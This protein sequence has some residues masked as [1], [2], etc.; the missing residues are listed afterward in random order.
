MI[1]TNAANAWTING[2]DAGTLGGTAF[3]AIANLI[4]G[5]GADSF[6][7]AGTGSISGVV[8]GGID[9]SQ[10]ATP[11]TDTLDFG[12][13]SGPV[14]VDLGAAEV[15]GVVGSFTA[16][17]R[18]KGSAGGDTLV[19]PSGETSATWTIDAA[20]AGNVAGVTFSS[21]ENLTGVS[22][23][24]S[25][26][27]TFEA[28]GSISGTVDGGSGTFDSI[29]VADGAG[30]YTIFNPASG[31]DNAGTLALNG[32]TI[33]YAGIDRE[34]LFA[35]D[36]LARSI[37]GT[38]FGDTIV[39]EDIGSAS[40]GMM[41]VRFVGKN[42]FDGSTTTSGFT[43][44]APADSLKIEGR[45]GSDSIEVK[46][47]D[48]LFSAD[49]LLYGS[50]LNGFGVPVD[51]PFVDSIVFSGSIDTHDGILDAWADKIE[52]GDFVHIDV[53]AQY[54]NFRARLVG[55]AE[56]ENLLP[57]FG[58]SRDVS[59]DIGKGAQ[60]S[61]EGGIF[62]IAQ[63]E[64]KNI[65]GLAGAPREVD[66]FVIQPLLDKVSGLTA[67]PV[68]LLVKN[69]SATITLQEGAKV[70]SDSTVG[71]YATASADASGAASGSLFSI[72][73]SRAVGSATID[74]QKDVEIVSADEAVVITSTGE[75]TASLSSST[76]RTLDSTPNPGGKDAQVAI[77]IAVSDANAT[78]HVN[79][80]EG[81]TIT[82][83]K[84]ANITAGGEVS[85]EAEAESGIFA[86]G[87]AG[88]AFALQFS[89]ADIKTTMLGSVT[90]YAKPDYTVKIEIDP[91]VTDPDTDGDG[92]PTTNPPVGYV[93]YADNK[94][95]VGGNSLVTEDTIDYTNRFGTSIGGLVDGT[96]YYVVTVPDMPGWI[97]LA[98]TETQAIKAGL[99]FLDGNVVD[100]IDQSGT[101]IATANNERAFEGSDV[102]A[103]DNT[104]TLRD[105]DNAPNNFNKF[106][107]GQAVV[108][109]KG[110]ADIDGL[111]DGNTYYV[112]VG[113]SENNLQ[114]DTRFATGQVVQLAESENEARAGVF[115]DIGS[116]AGAGG[117]KLSA[118]HVLDSNFAT[119]IGVVAKL[120]AEDKA[121]AS[122]GLQ[123][124]DK[125][126][127]KYDKFK[128][129]VDTNLGDL[130]FSKLTKSYADNQAKANSG[131][132]SELSVAGALAFSFGDHT[133]T[134][135]VGSKA[136]LKSNE[137]LEVKAN[138]EE[139]Y[140]LSAQSN[141]EPQDD[142]QGNSAGSS[143]DN[144]VSVAVDI[145]IY[146]NTATATVD[147]GAK[148]DGLRATRV[149][150]GVLYPFLTRPDKYIPLS[151]GELVDSIRSE[152]PDAITKYLTSTLGLKDSLFNSWTTA[153]AKADK[154]GIAGSVNV[155]VLT[156]VATATVKMGALINQDPTWHTKAGNDHPNQAENQA[157]LR[158][159]EVV[160]VEATNYMQTINMT[161][162]FAL[163]TFDFDPTTKD[164]FK[165]RISL[166]PSGTSGKK[167]GFGGAFFISVADN[168]THAV[169]EDG[170]EIYSGA[171]GGFNMKAEQ[172]ILAVNLVQAGGEGGKLAIGGSVAY[173]GITSD[174]LARLGAGA[175]V[176][177]RDARL[178]AG[179]L[180]TDVNWVGG[181]A[182]GETI[183]VGIAVGI[184][185][186]DRKT[187]AVIGDPSVLASD[188]T[189]GAA[190]SIN[191]SGD[192][193]VRAFV[194]G[195]LL[196]FAVAGAAATGSS[197]EAPPVGKAPAGASA[198]PAQ[199]DSSIASQQGT[200]NAI[201]AA[202]SLN[203]VS[204]DTRAAIVDAGHINAGGDTSVI[205]VDDLFHVAATGGVA[206]AKN[207]GS[208]S[209]NALAGALSFNNLDVDTRAYV[210]DT[211]ITSHDL[212][213]TS[214]RSGDLITVSASGAASTSANGLSLAGS[215]SVNRLDNTTHAFLQGANIHAGG[216]GTVSALDDSGIIAIG[217]AA[218]IGGAT[219][220]GFSIG[221]NEITGNTLAAID[222]STLS[223]GGALGLTAKN[224]NALRSVGVSAGLGKEDSIAVTIGVNLIINTDEARIT[225]STLTRA[226]SV[227]LLAQDDSVLQAIG[228]AIA[229]GFNG[230]G[231]GGSLG[232]NSVTN[233]IKA[234]IEDSSLTGVSGAVGV[235][236]ES[237]EDDALLDGKI[238][239]AAIGAAA[240]SQN[241]AAGGALAL[242]GII[243]SVDAHVSL[244]STIVAGGDVTVR[245]L[246]E[247]S[248]KSLTGGAAISLGGSAAGIGLSGN[249]IA[250]TVTATIDASSVT[251]SG[252]SVLVDVSETGA[253]D[254]I[255]IGLAGSTG[256]LAVAGSATINVIVD[257]V[258]ASVAGAATVHAAGNV[259]VKARNAAHAGVIAGQISASTGSAVGA[260]I[261]NATIVNHTS[262]WIDG[263]ATVTADVAFGTPFFTD[264]SGRSVRGVSIEASSPKDVEI[265]A[266]GG[267]IASDLAIAGSFSITVIDD[268][269]EAY[270]KDV[271]PGQSAGLISS[272]G[273]VNVVAVSSFGL[274]GAAGS[275]AIGGDAG[276]G[277][278]ADVGVA[279]IRTKAHI[280]DGA[281]VQA[282]DSVIVQALADERILSISI[283]GAIS[284]SVAVGVTAGVSVL[285]LDTEA[286][287][288]QGATASANGNAVVQALD[289]THIDI[290]TGSIAASGSVAVGVSG[291]VSVIN[292][293]TLSWIGADAQVS[294][295][296]AAGEAAF[297]ANTG[298]FTDAATVD[299]SQKI[300]TT[301]DFNTS[302]VDASGDRIVI[303][304]HGFS[305]DQEVIYSAGSQAVRGL[306]SGKRYYVHVVDANTI[307]LRQTA[308][309]ASS[310]VNLIASRPTT[311]AR[312]RAPA[313]R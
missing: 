20:D 222:D 2:A 42:F 119:G 183:G 172:A 132:Q 104:I 59:I 243:N 143:A 57:A 177:G 229:I 150:S 156:N 162:I 160:S 225:G 184:N 272:H 32:K 267:S 186:L 22:D 302:D 170:A 311:A 210:L 308:G 19:G 45:G 226:A 219:G 16:I 198:K 216:A 124:E 208:Q 103:A 131:G 282:D 217:G 273:D 40:D 28:G 211:D 27:F 274:I 286:W 105:A 111:V 237:T 292:K 155:L 236:A 306:T 218:A 146:N 157:D 233:T 92:D 68:K 83:G 213:V 48:S 287:I 303:A 275:I 65:A 239:S 255:A 200:T 106:E 166:N 37:G 17:D 12:A 248:I 251:S 5:K 171:D 196:S 245:A 161:G 288:G 129:K 61:S 74:I 35:G 7:F 264:A 96:N 152:G 126:P 305:E 1:A 181:I 139:K 86:D 220:V 209:A 23:S 271:A 310:T 147:G 50:S 24:V 240:S 269:T 278:G 130:L 52:V 136:V 247:S 34:D 141:T 80:A 203:I 258:S 81:A 256:E 25:D 120:T 238:S 304:N 235:V 135:E 118:K 266:I 18:V 140:V 142:G 300:S 253:V 127:S 182:K 9:D 62:L 44:L 87:K 13:L 72:G 189:I 133:V 97:R 165:E 15:A 66:N 174:T 90:A 4:G 134:T 173:N 301:K 110:T 285:T 109:H 10:L 144:S 78:S 8:D 180:E 207:T 159:E 187:H 190:N 112:V 138:I 228:G 179:D 194:G 113:T 58:T 151:A 122:A 281:R 201:A 116:A 77:S 215:I 193:K 123:S 108:Y 51:D 231:F 212:S 125:N 89:N 117:F 192:V 185:N 29:Q 43:F 254:S 82:A 145:G 307:E 221:F 121:S 30:G 202:V 294:A 137:D 114:G 227:S 93:D 175:I 41:Q 232:W 289:T 148:L 31:T 71:I 73:Y 263:L 3:S 168:T 153:T 276:I 64:D 279:T 69:S 101:P 55:I 46:S 241:I 163:P 244:G 224:D 195:E 115:I 299:R 197:P 164:S 49:L 234:R 205:A 176:T 100:L 88:L 158:G 191:V 309:D 178:Y 214:E 280:G 14:S 21:I 98:A 79:V 26:A 291:G 199:F 169:V 53:G 76:E 259:R 99:G 47:L 230:S 33:A 67:L 6:A 84:T 63:A 54:I 56:L 284:G 297:G 257:T 60:L 75:A 149:I 154:V 206:F 242:N 36:A 283:T 38:I 204:D 293:D 11:V 107:L 188:G 95:Y 223:F 249:F 277:I 290:V 246:D 250:N 252:G 268:T 94:I 262:A 261:T 91:L 85:S 39:L 102:N 70:L 265:F 312:R 128:E 167:G 298:T 260:S 270:V 296:A 295:R 313:T